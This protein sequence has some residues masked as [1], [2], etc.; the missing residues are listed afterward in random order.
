MVDAR[1]PLAEKIN[2]MRKYVVSSTLRA[3][4]WSNTHLLAGDTATGSRS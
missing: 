3:P 4:E 1:G 2:A